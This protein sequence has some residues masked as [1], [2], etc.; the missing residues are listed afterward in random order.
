VMELADGRIRLIPWVPTVVK[1]V[2]L[3]GKRIV[4]EWGADW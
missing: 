3:P 2:D 4:V 1:T